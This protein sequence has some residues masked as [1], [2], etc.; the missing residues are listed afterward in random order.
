MRKPDEN[1]LQICRNGLVWRVHADDAP[2]LRE[3]IIPS[4]SQTD[5]PSGLVLLKETDSRLI[6]KGKPDDVQ[7][8]F[9]VK[10]FK[11]HPIKDGVKNL[12][13]SPRGLKEWRVG[14]TLLRKAIP[15]P[16]PI[17]A[18]VPRKFSFSRRD[19][20]I[21]QEVVGAQ[22]LADWMEKEL[23][24]GSIPFPE[25]RVIIR[26]LAAFVRTLHDR[27]VYSTDL[28][29][30]NI[31]I[32]AAKGK[33]PRFYLTDFHAIRFPKRLSLRKR[34]NNLVQLNSFRISMADRLRFLRYYFQEQE[35]KG[36]ST[37]NAAREI[38]AASDKHWKHLWSKRKRRCL[39]PG[40]RFEHFAIG[41]WKGMMGKD[42]ASEEL[43]QLV[44]NAAFDLA[45]F[46]SRNIKEGSRTVIKEVAL[47]N[48]KESEHLVVKYYNTINILSKLKALF[49]M[50]RA[51][52]AWIHSH[53]LVMRGIPTPAPVAF[54]EKRP[55]GIRQ[56]SIFLTE[57]IPAAKGSDI[58][59][60]KH[61]HFT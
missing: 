7:G 56:E 57:K 21:S 15:A 13:R 8:S 40:R 9:I 11:R 5:Q 27:G 49:R 48:G 50:S 2:R 35:G 29:Q 41:K 46:R 30:G 38:G 53:Q 52:R 10:I 59:L 60:K 45:G 19:Y 4:L 18:G 22:S 37:K 43:Q 36:I 23:F 26:T 17:A 16:F 14:L 12:F 39:R 3:K 47:P 44:K 54:G 58:F 20:F 33:T 61:R 6:L 25:K 1:F 24:Q 34:V 32:K 51:E 42:R 55:W 31:L 28:H